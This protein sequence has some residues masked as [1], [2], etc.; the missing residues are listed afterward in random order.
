MG[1]RGKRRRGKGKRRKKGPGRGS[2][3]PFRRGTK[4]ELRLEEVGYLLEGE[5]WE[6]AGLVSKRDRVSR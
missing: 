6:W 2:S 3:H 4:G 1:Y 5:F